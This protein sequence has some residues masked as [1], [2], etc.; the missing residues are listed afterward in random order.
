MINNKYIEK[1]KNFF[2]KKK[3][4]N[5]FLY[6]LNK[7][8]KILIYNNKPF[9]FYKKKIINKIFN[10]LLFKVLKYK[11]QI[12]LIPIKINI[13]YFISNKKIKLILSKIKKSSFFNIK[14]IYRTIYIKTIPIFFNFYTI[15]DFFNKIFVNLKN[16]KN[17]K[18]K[19]IVSLFFLNKIIKKYNIININNIR[20]LF[21]IYFKSSI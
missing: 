12:L 7:K 19:K 6:N 5:F 1:F 8:K 9:I 13:P 21:F 17:I 3:P 4:K 16:Q 10:K 11:F 20:V 15:N 14:I 18:I 2:L